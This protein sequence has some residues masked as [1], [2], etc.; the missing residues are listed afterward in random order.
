LAPG[1]RAQ[2]GR[3]GQPLAV[4]HADPL[5]RPLALTVTAAIALIIA[6]VSPLMGLTVA[7]R[8]S[9]TT[10]IGGAY[11]MWLQGSEVTA[12]IVG[13]CAVFAPAAYVALLLAVL[14]MVRWPPAPA[15]VGVLM[16]WADRLRP[17]S[18]NEVLLLGMLV[19]LTK[20]AQLATV[21]PGA[22][23]YAIGALVLLLPAIV[24][25]FD[26][27]EVWRRIAWIDPPAPRRADP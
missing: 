21:I 22:G 6:N 7:G 2:C 11:Q 4:R 19:A 20:I 15:W 25:T 10:L 8:D 27:R 1:A 12:V 16:R 18:M 26:V 13:F 3:C 24:S 5:D 14:V 17:W 9:T 23:M